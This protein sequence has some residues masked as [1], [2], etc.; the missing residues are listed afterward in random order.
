MSIIASTSSGFAGSREDMAAFQTFHPIISEQRR[1]SGTPPHHASNFLRSCSCEV[2]FIPF[3]SQESA[4]RP[5]R[6]Q[7]RGRRGTSPSPSPPAAPPP[8]PS[9]PPTT[10]LPIPSPLPPPTPSPFP[11]YT[12]SGR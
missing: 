8:P 1:H 6:S 12:S 5:R 11:S 2:I 10:T 4:P 7:R 9:R 3:S